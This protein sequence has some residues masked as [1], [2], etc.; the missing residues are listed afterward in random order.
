MKNKT[1]ATTTLILFGLALPAQAVE[2]LT[3]TK[4]LA[5]PEN[6]VAAHQVQITNYFQLLIDRKE[7]VRRK[8]AEDDKLDL[9]NKADKIL[10]DNPDAK[11][12]WAANSE[13]REELPVKQRDESEKEHATRV[14]LWQKNILKNIKSFLG[15]YGKGPE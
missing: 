12:A 1:A 15:Q 7:V 3:G 9:K 13:L 8:R 2:C 11:N 6:I 4:S 14:V 10:L 5:M